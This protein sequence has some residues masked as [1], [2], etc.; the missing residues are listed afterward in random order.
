MRLLLVSFFCLLSR[1]ATA[2]PVQEH[3]YIDGSFGRLILL[4]GAGYKY[5]VCDNV[6]KQIRLYHT[7]HTLYKT[8]NVPQ[9]TGYGNVVYP[10]WVS[11]GL[12]NTDTLVEY[13]MNYSGPQPKYEVINENGQVI[14]SVPGSNYGT[15][16]KDGNGTF[17]LVLQS[18]F[19]QKIYVYSLPGFYPCTSCSIP[20]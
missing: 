13:T 14:N 4:S 1:L 12:F 16:F 5:M 6:N 8:M 2:Q 11:D 17:R 18:Y 7:D 15:V 10:N 9:Y 3:S 20:E 19:E